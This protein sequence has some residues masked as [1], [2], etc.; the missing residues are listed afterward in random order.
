MDVLVLS[1]R[2]ES[3]DIPALCARAG[4]L[5]RRGAPAY[6][7]CDVG[8]VAHPDAVCVEALAQLQLTVKRL[9][10]ELRLLHAREELK[11]LI[12][13]VGLCDAVRCAGSGVEPGGQAEQR[14]HPGGIQEEA[15]PADPSL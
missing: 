5:A 15:D 3:S 14:E 9:G 12:N 8:A 4:S 11:E 7:Y 13:L 1:G 2:I 10:R 6:V